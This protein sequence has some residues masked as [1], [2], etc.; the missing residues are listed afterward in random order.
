MRRI[1]CLVVLFAA[2]VGC[3]GQQGSGQPASGPGPATA[4]ERVADGVVVRFGDGLLKLEI[5]AADVV[6]VAYAKNESF[7]V[8]WISKPRR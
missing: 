8:R 5:C 6:R 4:V 7:F 2:F 3:A 1:V